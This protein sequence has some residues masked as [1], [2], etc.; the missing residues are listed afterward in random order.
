MGSRGGHPCVLPLQN[1]KKAT[2]SS[3]WSPNGFPT[4]QLGFISTRV[5]SSQIYWMGFVAIV[6]IWRKLIFFCDLAKE[7]GDIVSAKVFNQTIIIVNTPSGMREI[8]DKHH[9]SSSNRPYSWIA[10]QMAPNNINFGTAHKGLSIYLLCCHLLQIWCGCTANEAWWTF[11]KA[12]GLVLN[13][14]T[15]RK[16]EDYQYAEIAQL[17][18]D[19]LHDPEVRNQPHNRIELNILS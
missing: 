18:R 2:S 11:R 6:T 13:A 10:D 15:L 8:L 4:R 14:S 1:R 19:F 9:S 3:P 7:Y 16:Y 12:A 5:S 17:L